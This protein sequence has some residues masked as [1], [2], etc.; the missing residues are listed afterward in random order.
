MEEIIRR[1]A[2]C[3]HCGNRSPKRLIHTQRCSGTGWA[4]TDDKAVEMDIEYY[5]AICE[6]C[7]HVLLYRAIDSEVSAN[8][9]VHAD[10]EYPDS[11]NL[12]KSVPEVIRDIYD[13]AFRIKEIAPNAFAVQIRRALEALC[14]DRGAKDGVLQ[15]RLNDLVAKGEIPWTYAES[16]ACDII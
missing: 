16:R 12:H 11:G 8:D 10:L 4:I 15:K 13:E 7:D 3:P 2:F 14:E 5:V 9:F 6:T 1:V